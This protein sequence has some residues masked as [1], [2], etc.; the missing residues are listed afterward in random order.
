MDWAHSTRIPSIRSAQP[1]VSLTTTLS[2]RHT[3]CFT[4]V[5]SVY[6]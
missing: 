2:V 3:T 4:T 5:F 1:P 6:T